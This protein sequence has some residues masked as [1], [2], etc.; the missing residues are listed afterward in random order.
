[1]ETL[2]HRVPFKVDEGDADEFA[3]VMDEQREPI[4]LC[5]ARTKLT[6]SRAGRGRRAIAAG[7]CGC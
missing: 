5:Q 7:H 6:S 3:E 2:R 1:M 4:M